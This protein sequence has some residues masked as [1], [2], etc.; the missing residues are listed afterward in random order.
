MLIKLKRDD[1]FTVIELMISLV[2]L[3]IIAT[4]GVP[5]MADFLKNNK[6]KAQAYSFSA[7]LNYARSEAIKR[8]ERVVLCR[9]ANPTASSPTCG[10]TANTWT[11]GWLIFTDPDDNDVYNSGTDT[12]LKVGSNIPP[13]INI[14][15][16]STANNNIELNADGTTNEGG[17]TARMAI[18]D[19]RGGNYGRQI[20][21]SPLG[22]P[23]L[24]KGTPSVAINCTNP[25]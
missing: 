14:R 25:T 13:N 5:S 6:L 15:T 3:A 20:N 4:F 23:I 8:K 9:S 22:R 17:A 11:T 12:L 1:G 16:N 19:D 10:G 7:T 2:V 18:C 21:I 24:K